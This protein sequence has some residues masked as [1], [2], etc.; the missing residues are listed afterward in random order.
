MIFLTEGRFLVSPTVRTL[1]HTGLLS[2]FYDILILRFADLYAAAR[3]RIWVGDFE[4]DYIEYSWSVIVWIGYVL[5]RVFVREIM[6]IPEEGFPMRLFVSESDC[7]GKPS[8]L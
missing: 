4:C 2:G 1:I 5:G 7:R 8:A 3:W 6:T